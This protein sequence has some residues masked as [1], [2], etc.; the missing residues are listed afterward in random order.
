MERDSFWF[1]VQTDQKLLTDS[2][3][4]FLASEIRLCWTLILQTCENKILCAVFLIH[5]IGNDTSVINVRRLTWLI[6]ASNNQ[7][8]TSE[9]FSVA[10]IRRCFVKKMF[11]KT[12]QN[13][14]ENPGVSLYWN[15]RAGVFLWILW[16]I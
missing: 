15:S 10:A 6:H 5:W 9:S 8:V 14:H 2:D 3:S 7:I 12:F 13:S 4:W 11:L 16:N 1:C